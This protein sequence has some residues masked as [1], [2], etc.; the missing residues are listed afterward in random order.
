MQSF[1]PSQPSLPKL[2][3]FWPWL[4]QDYKL[5]DLYS[6]WKP[7]L[8]CGV[9][10]SCSALLL[11]WRNNHLSTFSSQLQLQW[12]CQVLIVIWCVHWLCQTRP[13][14]TINIEVHLTNHFLLRG[15]GCKTEE[16]HYSQ[17]CLSGA[18]LTCIIVSYKISWLTVNIRCDDWTWLTITSI[19]S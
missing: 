8:V 17:G 9:S 1:P 13:F 5:Q 4:Q 19:I 7:S 2:F 6:K 15:T 3:M 11:T 12:G 16:L 14:Q 18:K 10:S